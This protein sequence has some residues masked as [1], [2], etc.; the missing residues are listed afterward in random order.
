MKTYLQDQWLRLW[1]LGGESQ[2]DYAHP[3]TQVTHSSADAF[4]ADLR[5]VWSN[6]RTIAHSEARLIVRFGGINDRSVAPRDVFRASISESG[7]RIATIRDAKPV[8]SGKRQQR[9]FGTSVRKPRPEIDA[10]C[11]LSE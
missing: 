1:F 5:S 7:W 3:E 6:L 4:T 11:V 8:E 9:Q 10:Y 2:V